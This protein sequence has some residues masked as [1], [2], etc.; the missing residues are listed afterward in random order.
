VNVPELPTTEELESLRQVFSAFLEDRSPEKLVRQAME[1]ELGFDRTLWDALCEEIGIPGLLVPTALGGGGGSFVELLAVLEVSGGALVCAPLLSSAVAV[2]IVLATGD[3]EMQQRLLPGIANGSRIAAVAVAEASAGWGTAGLRTVA[4]CEQDDWRLTG[5][6]TFVIDGHLADIFVVS[7]RTAHGSRLFA[8][9]AGSNGVRCRQQPTLDQTRRLALLEL[10]G[11]PAIPLGPTDD[12]AAVRRSLDL[13][14]VALSAEQLGGAARCLDQA[15]QYAKTRTQ[16][17]RPIGSFQAIKHTCADMLVQVET[18]RS[19]LLHAGKAIASG[20]EDL[21]TIASV[22]KAACS[23]AY[24]FTANQN[25]QIHGGIG[26]A[27]EHSAHLHLKR[28]QS[29]ALLFGDPAHHR[30]LVAEQIGL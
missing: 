23:E 5:T 30:E 22:C 28:A 7:A 1:S 20:T 6:K 19:A 26:F 4:E 8:V 25:V 18:C 3:D 14:A 10:D 12:G 27:W 17:D 9:D 24:L 11:A 15:V 16:F 21:S 29:S 13:F 2:A